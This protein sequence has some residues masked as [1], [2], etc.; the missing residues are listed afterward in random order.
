MHACYNYN[1]LET[2]LRGFY[3]NNII[4]LRIIIMTRL[5]FYITSNILSTNLFIVII[6]FCRLSTTVY[7]YTILLYSLS[8]QM[9]ELYEL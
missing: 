4:L 5:Y 6:I 8:F 9:V 7:S 3:I 2:Q 1:Q